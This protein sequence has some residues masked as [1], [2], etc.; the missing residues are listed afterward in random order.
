MTRN[1]LDKDY[2]YQQY[3]VEGRSTVAI[4]KEH[5][6]EPGSVLYRLR[7]FGIPSRNFSESHRKNAYEFSGDIEV[8]YGSL[9]GDASLLKRNRKTNQG[10]ASFSKSNVGYDHVVYV[11][12][13]VLNSDPRA[14]IYEYWPDH[15]NR[16]AFKFTTLTST[17]FAKEHDRWYRGNIKTVPRDLLLTPKVV[18]HWFLDDGHSTWKHGG[19]RSVNV[20]FAT[21]SFTKADC[22]QLAGQ[23]CN[24]GVPSYLGKSH[25]G[26][27]WTVMVRGG[28][29]RDFFNLIGPC[30]TEIPSMAYK[31]KVPLE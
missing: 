22:E 18:L 23:L 4:A 29:V 3:V 21:E 7:K 16:P 17:I 28:S 31:W 11:G 5:G 26:F 24:L 20:G 12:Q 30:P 27:G 14:R 10:S 2:L 6:I 25:G 19:R 1:F 15:Y 8:V 9:L 13:A